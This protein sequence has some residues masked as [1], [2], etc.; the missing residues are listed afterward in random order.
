MAR[1]AA[2]AACAKGQFN[3]LLLKRLLPTMPQCSVLGCHI[4]GDAEDQGGDRI[5]RRIVGLKWSDDASARARRPLK[6][7]PSQRVSLLSQEPQEQE[8]KDLCIIR[9]R[10][11]YRERTPSLHLQCYRFFLMQNTPTLY[12]DI[13]LHENLRTKVG[14]TCVHKEKRTSAIIRAKK[15]YKERAP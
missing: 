11:M 8:N 3:S 12:S 1:H 2:M 5:M 6:S 14:S 9:C 7:P 10:K 15:S 13:S 4:P